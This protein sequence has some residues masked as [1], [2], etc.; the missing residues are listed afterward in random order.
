MRPKYLK[1]ARPLQDTESLPL[2]VR[3]RMQQVAQPWPVGASRG[4]EVITSLLTS[5]YET[6]ANTTMCLG[7]SCVAF[8]LQITSLWQAFA[9][10]G[11][12]K[13]DRYLSC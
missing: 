3:D 10:R 13:W 2:H 8:A 5:F 7:G 6:I 4:R 1:S 9:V 11:F 12:M